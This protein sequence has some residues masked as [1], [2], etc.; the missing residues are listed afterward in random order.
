MKKILE[1]IKNP[2]SLRYV[3]V[4]LATTAV[5]FLVY[6]LAWEALFGNGV[7]GALG[8]AVSQVI[9]ILFAFFPNKLF[10]FRSHRDTRRGVIAELL[11]FFGT[12]MGTFFAS[13]LLVFLLTDL[14]GLPGMIGKGITIVV[15]FIGNYLFS[16]WLVF[17]HKN[18]EK[19]K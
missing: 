1:L 18:K 4:G 8:E 17:R 15:C 14:C 19:I 5:G 10:V 7:S 16:K 2:E 9:A 11:S 13:I 12:R 3:I 6:P